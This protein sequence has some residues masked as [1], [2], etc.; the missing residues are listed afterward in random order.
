MPPDVPAAALIVRPSARVLLVDA[1]DRVLLFQVHPDQPHAGGVWFTP[2]GGVEVG[3]ALRSTAARELAE[4]TGLA[5][6]PDDLVGPVWVR[7]HVGPVVDSRETFFALRIERHE[8][9]TS[10]WTDLERD[11][12]AQYRWWSVP[13]LAAATDE[14]FAPRR[15]AALLPAVLAG[16]SGPPI[17]VGV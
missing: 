12:F 5:A 7:R 17:E 6:E 2:G 9:D 16:W 10:S 11:V 15:I 8:V 13:Q 14:V 1:S 3:E 4:E